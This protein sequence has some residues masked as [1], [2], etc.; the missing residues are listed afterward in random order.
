MS[1]VSKELEAEVRRECENR[2]GYCLL[3]QELVSNKLE[4]EHI[5]P[6]GKGGTDDKENL[7]LAC[8]ECNSHKAVKTH[9][10]DSL[11]AKQTKLFNPRKQNWKRHFEFSEDKTEIIGKTVCGRATVSALQMNNK[12]QTTARKYWKLTDIFPPE[13]L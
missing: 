9:G 7:C 11:M 12:L 6:R 2:C 13:D 3:P 8:R 4:I 5:V 10:F 1:K